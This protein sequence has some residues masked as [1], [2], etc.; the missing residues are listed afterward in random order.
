MSMRKDIK[1]EYVKFKSYHLVRKKEE[2]KE[3]IIQTISVK[4]YRRRE[5]NSDTPKLGTKNMINWLAADT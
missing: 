5:K 3:Y 1:I 2:K 4:M